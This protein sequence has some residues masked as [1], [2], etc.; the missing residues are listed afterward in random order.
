MAGQSMLPIRSI[1]QRRGSNTGVAMLYAEALANAD[2]REPGM[3][4]R[5]IYDRNLAAH[6]YFRKMAEEYMQGLC[7]ERGTTRFISPTA[8]ERMM[9]GLMC[10]CVAV[11]PAGH[12]RQLSTLESPFR[13]ELDASEADPLFYEPGAPCDE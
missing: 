11:G 9:L 4:E 10:D 3:L 5:A 8:A 12:F 13:A 1:W 6:I 7:D 2:R